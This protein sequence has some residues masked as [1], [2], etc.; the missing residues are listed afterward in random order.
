MA[1]YNRGQ[2][3]NVMANKERV[4]VN[5]TPSKCDHCGQVKTGFRGDKTKHFLFRFVGHEGLFCS[6]KCCRTKAGM[7][8]DKTKYED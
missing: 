5:G 4:F 6:L 8:K 2:K 7:P 1:N 3:N